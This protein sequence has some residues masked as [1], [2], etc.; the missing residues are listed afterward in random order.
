MNV[1]LACV[2]KKNDY[3]CMAKDMYTSD[4][5]KKSL[6]YAYS[7]HPENIYILS[8]KYGL[9]ELDDLIDTYDKTLLHMTKRERTDWYNMVKNQMINKG[10]NFNS[11]TIFLCG[12]KYREGIIDLFSDYEIPTEHMGIGKQLQ[13]FKNNKSCM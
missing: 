2:K 5:F 4:L 6:E 9:L 3:S 12:A 1:F 13:F 8:A 10:I 7:L 11:K